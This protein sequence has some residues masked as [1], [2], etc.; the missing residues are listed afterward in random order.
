MKP[1][2][3]CFTDSI[4]GIETTKYQ[5]FNIITDEFDYASIN[6]CKKVL[7]PQDIIKREIKSKSFSS[8]VNL[9]SVLE[10]IKGRSK[11][12]IIGSYDKD[13]LDI[14]LEVL[15]CAKDKGIK[16][17]Y[18]TL[19][20]NIKTGLASLKKDINAID[21]GYTLNTLSLENDIKDIYNNVVRGKN[22]NNTS[23][24]NNDSVIF[25]NTDVAPLTD[26]VNS[27]VSTRSLGFTKKKLK[28]VS[29]LT[30]FSSGRVASMY[31]LAKH[32][33]VSSIISYND[34]KQIRYN[35]P[36]FAYDGY[37]NTKY[38]GLKDVNTL[39]PEILKADFSVVKIKKLKELEKLGKLDSVNLIICPTMVT[40]GR[41]R[42]FHN[43]KKKFKD[44][45][46]YSL[47]STVLDLLGLK[48]LGKTLICHRKEKNGFIFRIS[49]IIFISCFMIYYIA[50]FIYYYLGR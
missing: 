44:G 38:K 49:S 4:D 24:S 20:T 39:T 31:E 26:F 41:L 3:L 37:R 43:T 27:I 18:I 16:R 25:F 48:V 50:R 1:V 2:L 22:D 32:D 5:E 40:E 36:N 11:L 12:H 13:D 19:F 42:C 47:G 29:L 30:V 21:I 14:L 45:E 34:L 10:K 8:N 23:I 35:V 7:S 17:V 46:I 6:A 9:L 28:G 33:T 15:R